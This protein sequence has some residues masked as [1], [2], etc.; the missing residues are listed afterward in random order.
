MAKAT[1]KAAVE[2]YGLRFGHPN[3]F[4]RTVNIGTAAKPNKVQLVFEPDTPLELT[5]KEIEGLKAEIES[6]FIVPWG[7]DG[8]RR[9]VANPTADTADV[10]R[11]QAENTKLRQQ[12]AELTNQLED[13]TAPSSD[14]DS[15]LDDAS[16]IE[17]DDAPLGDETDH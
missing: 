11:L 9:R 5:D 15:E 3:T 2:L 13:A 7:E 6:G 4:R 17:D 1:K 10:K 8:K 16:Q 12:V 14:D